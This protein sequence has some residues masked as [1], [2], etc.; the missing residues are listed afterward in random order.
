MRHFFSELDKLQSEIVQMSEMVRSSVHRSIRCLVERNTDFA[1]QVFRDEGLINQSEITIDDMATRLVT[2]NAPVA[3]D[4]RLLIAALKMNT[5][6][7]R[8]GD[9]AVNCTRRAL[10]LIEQ[11]P[12]EVPIPIMSE[13]VESMIDNCTRAFTMRDEDLARSVLRA[14]DEVDRMRSNVYEE[15]SGQMEKD[16]ALVRRGLMYMFIARNLERIA[17]HATNIA[18]DVI[19]LV[20]GIDVRHHNEPDRGAPKDAL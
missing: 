19:Y 14:D 1:D 6:L 18:E 15:L 13:L 17:D 16:P 7:E 12:I 10:T 11:P 20:K 9:L 5:D 3:G 8:M 4:M 2:L